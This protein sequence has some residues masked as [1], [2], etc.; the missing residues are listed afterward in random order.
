M[1]LKQEK[2]TSKL[3]NLVAKRYNK[4]KVGSYKDQTV[5]GNDTQHACTYCYRIFVNLFL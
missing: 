4:D 5:K 2:H 1:R 3:R